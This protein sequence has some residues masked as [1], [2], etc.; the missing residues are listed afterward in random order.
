MDEKSFPI[1]K[2]S[3]QIKNFSDCNHQFIQDP[4]FNYTNIMESMFTSIPS[5]TDTQK[6]NEQTLFE[7]FKQTKKENKDERF[8]DKLI[9]DAFKYLYYSQKMKHAPEFKEHRQKMEEIDHN[10]KILSM[11]GTLY[12]IYLIFKKIDLRMT[13]YDRIDDIIKD[14]PR[15]LNLINK[16]FHFSMILTSF[17]LLYWNISKS[18]RLEKEYQDVLKQKYLKNL[19]ISKKHP[20]N[21]ITM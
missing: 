10:I 7:S 12:T 18:R 1:N 9:K 14:K 20:Q 19:S 8:N 13:Y 21:I 17:S 4:K 3:D 16:P 2:I 11:M 15:K 6:L 5:E